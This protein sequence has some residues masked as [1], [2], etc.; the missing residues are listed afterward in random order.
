M[1]PV[2]EILAALCLSLVLLLAAQALLLRDVLARA[3]VERS[4]LQRMAF[5]ESKPERIAA[6]MPERPTGDPRPATPPR[7]LEGI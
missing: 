2:L 3:E 5:A 6:V 1:R 4:R 7:R